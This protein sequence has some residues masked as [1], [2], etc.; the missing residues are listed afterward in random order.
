MG[1]FGVEELNPEGEMFN[2][3]FHQAMTLAPRADVPPNTVVSVVQK[4]Y[5][6]NGRLV[7]PALVI[8]SSGG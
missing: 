8:V 1:K 7:R 6:L 2:P 3:E 4:G 5:L